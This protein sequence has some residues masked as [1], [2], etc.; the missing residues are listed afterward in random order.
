MKVGVKTQSTVKP[1]QFNVNNLFNGEKELF[2]A[3][4]VVEVEKETEQG[5]KEILYDYVQYFCSC[6]FSTYEE[7]V[8][9]LVGLKYS[10]GDE[11]S[12]MR[13]G[14]QNEDDLEYVEY[15]DYVNDCKIFAKQ[16]F[17]EA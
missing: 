9:S 15:V 10:T 1:S 7:L 8:S 2:Y 5:E 11:I 14:I 16:Y 3:D 13:K 4:E 6:K 17:S 12:L